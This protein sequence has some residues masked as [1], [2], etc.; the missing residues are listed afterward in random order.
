[1][2]A[3]FYPISTFNED[4]RVLQG[5]MAY[6]PVQQNNATA[7]WTDRSPDA[8]S[9]VRALFGFTLSLIIYFCILFYLCDNY[10][11]ASKKDVDRS[12]VKKVCVVSSVINCMLLL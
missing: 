7:S 2:N 6:G 3:E 12:I 11:D 8:V 10:G 1:M 4:E 9:Y 5:W